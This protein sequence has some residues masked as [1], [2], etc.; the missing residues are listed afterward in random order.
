MTSQGGPFPCLINRSMGELLVM[1]DLKLP[2]RSLT[3]FP[4][5]SLVAGSRSR[6]LTAASSCQGVVEGQK[7][8]PEP[9]FLQAE[10]LSSLSRSSSHLC[11]RPFPSSLAEGGRAARALAQGPHLGLVPQVCAGC[12]AQACTISPG[13]FSRGKASRRSGWDA[14]GWQSAESW[15]WFRSWNVVEIHT[16]EKEFLVVHYITKREKRKHAEGG[17]NK[18]ASVETE[19]HGLW[20]IKHSCEGEGN[21]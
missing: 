12:F 14:P 5:L 4:L 8:L 11:S 9:S 7:V 15:T 21:I 18:E 17:K 6:P 10:P 3:P 1:S 20:N 13:A 19:D 2:W 16:R